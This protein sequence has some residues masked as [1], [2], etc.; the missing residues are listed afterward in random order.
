MRMTRI[1][2]GFGANLPG[3]QGLVAGTLISALRQIASDPAFNLIGRSRWFRTPAFPAGSGP[4]FVNGAA[5]VETGEPPDSVLEMLH[6]IEAQLGRTRTDRWE[7]RVCDIDLIAAEGTMLPDA[8]TLASWI[9]LDRGKAQQVIPPR[10]ILPHPRMH[11]RAFVLVPLLD[12]APD[13]R[14]PLLDLTIRE[15]VAMLPAAE[16]DEVVALEDVVPADPLSGPVQEAPRSG[17]G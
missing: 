9:D 14:H 11:E 16:R 6:A 5:L 4:D 10:L 2:L 3:A 8:G 15:M 7:P 1:L 13:W 17:T 12:V